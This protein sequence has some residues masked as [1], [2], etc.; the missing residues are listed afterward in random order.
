MA[1]AAAARERAA[2]LRRELE[3]HNRLYYVEDAPEITDAEYDR[4]FAELQRLETEHPELATPDSPTQRIGAP[5]LES[6]PE[7]RHRTPMLSLANAFDEDAV[8]AFD[9]RAREA[10]GVE[11]ID[12][13]VEP[14][15]DGL[16]V[17]LSYRD[18]LLVQGATRGDGT[19]GEDVTPNLRTVRSI[20]LRLPQAPD[21]RDLE[22]RGEVLITRREFAALNERQRAAGEKE[23]VNARNAAA[24]SLRQ[25]DSRVTALRPLRFFAYGVGEVPTGAPPTHAKVL[26]RLAALGFPVAEERGVA[27]GVEGLLAYYV[28]IGAKRDKL[29]YAIDGVVYKVDR[30]DWQERLGYVA[31]APRFALAHKYPAEEQETEVLDIDV[32]VGRTGVLTPVARLKPVFVGGVTVTNATLHNED[33]LRR[34]DVRVGDTVIVRRAGDVIPEVVAV[35]REK[36]PAGTREFHMP[37]RCPVCHSPV[38]RLPGEAATRCTGG[39]YC[40]AQRIGALLHFKDRRAMDIEGLGDKLAEQLV[41]S[42]LVENPADLYALEADQLAALARMGDKSARNVI[43][44]IARSRDTTLARFVFALG[45]PGVGEEVAKIL[46]RHFRALDALLEADW[47]ALAAEKE[48]ARKDNAK[49]KRRGEAQA[50]VP[51]EGIGPE[52]MDSVRQFLSERHNRRVI[53]RL[54]DARTGVRIAAEVAPAPA[55]AAKT[56]VLTGTLP[57]MT[58]D[59]AKSLIESKGHKVA[60]SVSRNTDYVVAGEEAGSKLERA[61]ELGVT[62]LDERGLKDTLDRL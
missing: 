59:E 17:S 38:I 50:P 16:A 2:K 31:R 29:P 8:H 35:Q 56:F 42:E 19:R 39:L 58:R 1:V 32:Q 44:S 14:K 43:D 61:R 10:L 51:L 13:C 7:V 15:F 27:H 24:G 34:K 25:L 18:G 3:R 12:Y 26:E 41:D 23:F 28:C 60:G 55:R 46:A 62:I 11:T 49:R 6:F 48:A 37:T 57:H 53:E 9:R 47:Q 30:L 52:I 36:R 40:P 22:V 5:P 33:D 20:P 54:V 45:I 4:L 21:T